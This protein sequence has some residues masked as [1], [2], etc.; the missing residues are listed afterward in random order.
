MLP[1]G[2]GLG[3]GGDL[4]FF[5]NAFAP[6]TVHPSS[7]YQGPALF[8]TTYNPLS[9]MMAPSIPLDNTF[10]TLDQVNASPSPMSTFVDSPSALDN[11]DGGLSGPKPSAVTTKVSVVEQGKFSLHGA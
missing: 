3:I 2:I 7:Y 11:T 9:T 4:A 6:I 5:S 1:S 10:G 8:D